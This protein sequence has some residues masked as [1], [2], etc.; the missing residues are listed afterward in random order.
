[1]ISGLHIIPLDGVCERCMIGKHHEVTLQ[2]NL[3]EK[4]L[5]W[6]WSIVTYVP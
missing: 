1:M 2:G 4:I 5:G 6:K 3:G